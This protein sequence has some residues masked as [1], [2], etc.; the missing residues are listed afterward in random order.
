MLAPPVHR[1]DVIVGNE[2]LSS[3]RCRMKTRGSVDDA[4]AV[5]VKDTGTARWVQAV[6]GLDVT[7]EHRQERRGGRGHNTGNRR[8]AHRL[9]SVAAEV[10]AEVVSYDAACDGCFPVIT[11]EQHPAGE[12]LCIYK[13]QPHLE[14]RRHTFKSA[15]EAA[16][17]VLKSDAWIDVLAF[18]LYVARL[19]HALVERE[20]RVAM[21]AKDVKRLPLW[22]EDRSG[23]SPTAER[24]FQV[25]EPPSA[26]VLLHAGE[27]LMV[28]PPTLDHLQRQILGLLTIPSHAYRVDTDGQGQSR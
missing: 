15:I 26:T 28:S 8:I 10:G 9:S 11:T 18:C 13:A 5:V 17:F 21:A 19:V 27:G 25:L 24:V 23:S 12:V 6:V 1:S 4:V 22:Y 2:S 14:R 3:P 7:Y 16:P 20:L